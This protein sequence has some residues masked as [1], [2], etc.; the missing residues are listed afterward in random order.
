MLAFIRHRKA[1]QDILQTLNSD[2]CREW[3]GGQDRKPHCHPT[4]FHT[5]NGGLPPRA[6]TLINPTSSSI[7]WTQPLP[8]RE[9]NTP[10]VHCPFFFFFFFEDLISLRERARVST[11]IREEQ[12]ER[13]KQTPR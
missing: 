11:S 12:R 9:Q 10:T 7:G 6:H 8:L 2:S 3:A 1:Y 4:C 5:G 13:E